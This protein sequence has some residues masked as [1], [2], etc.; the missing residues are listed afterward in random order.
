MKHVKNTIIGV[1]VLLCTALLSN[2]VESP[3]PDGPAPGP[4][5]VAKDLIWNWEL[6]DD[7]NPNKFAPGISTLFGYETHL[8]NPALPEKYAQ[9]FVLNEPYVK[10]DPSTGW[11]KTEMVGGFPRV[12]MED[13][14]GYDTT[15]AWPENRGAGALVPLKVPTLKKTIGPDGD[16]VEAFYF[17]GTMMQVG[18]ESENSDEWVSRTGPRTAG[19]ASTGPTDYR[20]SCGWPAI[21]LYATPPGED[22]D[23]EQKT[24][25]AFMD[26]YGYTFWV[27]SMKDYN[28]YRTSVENSEYRP[29]EGHEPGHWYGTRAG[30]DADPTYNFTPAPPEEW[31]KVTVIYDPS[32]PD[33]NMDVNNWI[34]QYNVQSNYLNDREP[35]NIMDNHNKDNSIRIAFALQLQHNGGDEGTDLIEYSVQTGRHDYEVYFYGLE[36]LQY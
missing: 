4:G 34:K 17:Y 29:N 10:G 11:Y 1:C 18:S 24:L 28:A 19:G 26:G 14:K 20:L 7:I 31:T 16:E 22:I 32:H 3:P 35:Y 9:A 13:A 27:K 2:C 5:V 33:F 25:L 15:K 23:P 30:R 8:T 21:T 36:I 12:V 6:A